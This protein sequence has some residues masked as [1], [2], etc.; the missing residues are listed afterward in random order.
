MRTAMVLAAGLGALAGPALADNEAGV[1]ELVV[2]GS[3]G[4]P[5]LGG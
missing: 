3:R 4:A 1:A 2:V 5:R